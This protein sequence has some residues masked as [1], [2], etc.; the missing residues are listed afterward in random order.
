MQRQT[1][2]HFKQMWTYQTKTRDVSNQC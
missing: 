2:R 1:Q